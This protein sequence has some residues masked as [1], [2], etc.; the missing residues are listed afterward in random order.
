VRSNAVP[1]PQPM[2][3]GAVFDAKDK[4]RTM[5]GLFQALDAAE[6]GEGLK[7]FVFDGGS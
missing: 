2:R 1:G 5:E 7:T 3:L 6:K 4:S